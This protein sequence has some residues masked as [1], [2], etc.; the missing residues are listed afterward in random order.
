MESEQDNMDHGGST[1]RITV[2]RIVVA[3]FEG[4]H[5]TSVDK[6]FFPGSQPP[7][8]GLFQGSQPNRSRKQGTREP[9]RPMTPISLLIK[10]PDDRSA[11]KVAK[12]PTPPTWTPTLIPT[13]TPLEG[14]QNHLISL[15][16]LALIWDLGWVSSDALSTARQL[17][18]FIS[19]CDSV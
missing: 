14:L 6:T 16:T 11:L 7:S 18:C 8:A 9:R 2:R 12:G 5:S 10:S 3:S 13:H 4:W 19:C 1:H 15:P 17:W